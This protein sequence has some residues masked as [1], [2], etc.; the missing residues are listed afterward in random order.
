MADRQVVKLQRA[1][2][3]GGA[4][5]AGGPP[6]ARHTLPRPGE[7]A[8]ATAAA[9]A[10]SGA[11]PGLFNLA[12]VTALLLFATLGLLRGCTP[13]GSPS[14]GWALRGAASPYRD[15]GPR[16][17][18]R[19]RILPHLFIISRFFARWQPGLGPVSRGAL[20]PVLRW[21]RRALLLRRLPLGAEGVATDA[22]VHMQRRS[23]SARQLWRWCWFMATMT[24]VRVPGWRRPCPERQTA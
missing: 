1:A 9:L 21:P 3:P 14:Q 17:I 19:C 4:L 12:D 8:G 15:G 2:M 16:G 23:P 20:Q 24:C 18:I 11:R 7:L 6:A 10:A 22:C 13:A 5:A